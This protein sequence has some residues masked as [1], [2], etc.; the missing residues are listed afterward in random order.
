MCSEGSMAKDRFFG[1]FKC[2]ENLSKVTFIEN[3]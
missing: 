3:L 1:N 2:E